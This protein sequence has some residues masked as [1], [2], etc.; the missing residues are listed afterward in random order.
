MDHD[1]SCH[2]QKDYTS[3]LNEQPFSKDTLLK[4]C[5]ISSIV[6]TFKGGKA[7]D[8]GNHWL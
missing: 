4:P 3:G 2:L 8:D 1:G 6:P 5:C 7:L